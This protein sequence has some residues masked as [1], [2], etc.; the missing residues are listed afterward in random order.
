MAE[1]TDL[2]RA[3]LM[4]FRDG[5]KAIRDATVNRFKDE[6]A[7]KMRRCRARPATPLN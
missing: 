7:A 6:I 4:G 1:M 5:L 3:Y 2:K